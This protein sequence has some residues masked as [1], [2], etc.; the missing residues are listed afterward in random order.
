MWVRRLRALRQER[1][2]ALLQQV[3]K[4]KLYEEIIRQLTDL[5]RRGALRPGDRL[6]SERDLAASLG[7]SR[8]AIREA[9]RSMESMGMIESRVGGGTFIRKV[10]LDSVIDSVSSILS[11]DRKLI[12][13]L[14]D[15]RYLLEGEVARLA[16]RCINDRKRQSIEAA[17]TL[18]QEEIDAGGTGLAGDDAFHAALSKASGNEAL[19]M[20]LGMCGDLLS[21]TRLATLQIP[22]QPAKS[23][24]DHRAIFE[25]VSAGDET[26]AV[27]RMQEHLTKAQLNLRKARQATPQP[28]A[29]PRDSG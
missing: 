9:L 21:S 1:R 14:L 26:L 18:M 11:L 16:A 23:L 12:L 6:P 17:L 2:P 25:A 3:K 22:G 13:E 7:V 8:T 19:S 20:L 27:Q 5:M 4:T 28:A 15:V 10:T 29:G 24:E